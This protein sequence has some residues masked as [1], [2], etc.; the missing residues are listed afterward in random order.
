MIAVFSGNGAIPNMVYAELSQNGYFNMIYS[1]ATYLEQCIARSII[2]TTD[3]HNWNLRKV[4]SLD[5]ATDV[6]WDAFRK[7]A[8]GRVYD[9]LREKWIRVPFD[10]INCE[11]VLREQEKIKRSLSR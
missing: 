5:A 2:P 8:D 11:M 4:G 3:V 9:L 1:Q 10:K 7:G 6:Y